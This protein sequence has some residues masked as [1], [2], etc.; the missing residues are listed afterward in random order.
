LFLKF[1]IP[2][3]YIRSM[4]H[5]TSDLSVTQTTG[6]EVG[7]LP[8]ISRSLD[9]FREIITVLIIVVVA[10]SHSTTLQT[11]PY[12]LSDHYDALDSSQ[13]SNTLA[14]NALA[15]MLVRNAEVV[16]V[17]ASDHLG[18]NSTY[19]VMTHASE[20]GHEPEQPE[21]EYPG[22]FEQPLEVSNLHARP[23]AGSL[24]PAQD[25]PISTFTA[26]TNPSKVFC[27]TGSPGHV[28]IIPDCPPPNVT[29]DS[30]IAWPSLFQ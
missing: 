15:I 24:P 16:V 5:L 22:D 12:D 1:K 9:E 21:Y 19:R 20:L 11:R 2:L 4:A 25:D 30:S 13:S 26:L 17:T 28:Y 3:F 18:P 7:L 14:L 8:D 27:E 29:I 23:D 6:D 10:H